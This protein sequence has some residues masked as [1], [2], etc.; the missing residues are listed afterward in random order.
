M[1]VGYNLPLSLQQSIN[2]QKAK[3]Y[4]YLT[5]LDVERIHM[6]IKTL[7]WV[8]LTRWSKLAVVDEKALRYYLKKNKNIR[9]L[10][11]KK[12]IHNHSKTKT[13]RK[14]RRNK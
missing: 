6:V 2:V 4:K 13:I 1:R 9:N 10:S 3:L 14:L 5:A 11:K 12:T 7:P 8:G